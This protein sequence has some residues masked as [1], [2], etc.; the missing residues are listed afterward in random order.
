MAFKIQA[1]IFAQSCTASYRATSMPRTNM[2]HCKIRCVF[3]KA[4]YWAEFGKG[5][6]SL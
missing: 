2:L 6:K 5:F 4:D 1:G 3:D